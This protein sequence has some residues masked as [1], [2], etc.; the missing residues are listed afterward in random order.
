MSVKNTVTDPDPGDAAQRS[1]GQAG[2]SG[3]VTFLFSDIEGSSRME[4][5]VGTHV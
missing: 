4:Q 3:T 5:D 1:Q 2:L